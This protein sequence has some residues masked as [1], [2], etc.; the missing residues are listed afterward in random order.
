MRLKN[1]LRLFFVFILAIVMLVTA[2]FSSGGF[3]EIPDISEGSK[4]F[5]ALNEVL[6]N[7]TKYN[8]FIEL[9]GGGY[10]QD[11][12]LYVYYREDLDENVLSS[13][14]SENLLQNFSIVYIPAEYS[15]K[16]LH[17]M[18]DE[19]WLTK[20]S[21]KDDEN[22]WTANLECISVN[23]KEN[24]L[25]CSL[26]HG[27]QNAIDSIFYN[28]S[29]YPCNFIFCDGYIVEKEYTLY[30]GEGVGCGSATVSI[31]FRCKKN[32]DPGFMTTIHSSSTG[33]T[34]YHSSTPIGQVTQSVDDGYA[35]FSFVKITDSNYTVSLNPK[36]ISNYHLQ[37]Y[38]FAAPLP[39]G[40]TV[41]LAGRTQYGVVSGTVV[42]DATPIPY[43]PGSLWLA[44]SYNSNGGD[45]GGCVFTQVA[46]NN[47]IIGVHDGRFTNTPSGTSYAYSTKFET[48]QSIYNSNIVLY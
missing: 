30:P 9:Y 8:D 3:L 39:V 23:Q 42:D 20:Y 1:Y 32:G 15:Y 21:H 25:E 37:T 44:C 11:D 46:G 2:G 13:L 12:T 38:H 31:G 34:V 26:L 41:F 10:I 35:D 5:N 48:I 14:V 18:V 43:N 28:L 6:I 29:T 19:I 22:H 7:N 47:I 40:Y 24:N 33:G 16:Q 45:S 17:D 4:A 36:G 27:E